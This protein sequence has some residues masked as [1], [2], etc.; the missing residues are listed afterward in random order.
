MQGHSYGI[1]AVFGIMPVVEGYGIL[2][3]HNCWFVFEELSFLCVFY[4]DQF[5][6][7]VLK[8]YLLDNLFAIILIEILHIVFFLL[9]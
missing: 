9:F 5:V 1:F 4:F 2:V 6:S 7:D 3:C 8:F